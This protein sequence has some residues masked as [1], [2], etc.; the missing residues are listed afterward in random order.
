MDGGGEHGVLR[1]IAGYTANNGG[2]LVTVS[3]AAMEAAICPDLRGRIVSA[4]EKASGKEL[5]AVLGNQTGYIDLFGRVAAQI[6][7]PTSENH[8]VGR[9][10]D[11]DWSRTWSTFA[12]ERGDALQTDVILSPS[13][14]GFYP[15]QWVRRTVTM[16]AKGMQI[17][18]RFIQEKATQ[19][20]L[21]NN[22][23]FNT[24]WLLALPAPRLTKVAVKGGGLEQML[25]LSYAVPGGITGVKAGERLAAGDNM[26]ERF[27]MVIA[28]SDAE[29][30]KLPVA[31]DAAGDLLVRL[32]RGDGTTVILSTPANGWEGIEIKPVI[33]RQYLEITLV[34]KPM[35][36]NKDNKEFDLPDQMLSAHTVPVA[37]SQAAPV[38][39]VSA[40]VAPRLK[41]AADGTA[42]N[43]ADGAKLIWIPAGAFTRGAAAGLGGGDERPQRQI[44]LDGYWIYQHPVTVGQYLKFC[45]ATGKEF[46]PTWGQGMQ[47][48]PHGADD[49]YAV[50]LNWYEADAYAK[51]ASAALPS[52]AQWEKAARATDGRVFPWGNDWDPAKCVSM[53]ATI[54]RFNTGFFPVGGHPDGAS[55][56]GVQDLA[57]NVWE[58]VADWYAYDYYARAPERNPL[59]PETGSHKVLRGGCALFDER[60]S[61]TTA[62]MIMPPH[63][64]DW[65]PTGFRC[66]IIAPGPAGK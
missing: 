45:E 16:T 3:G 28:V 4:V 2:P 37:M 62:R 23:R 63:V 64:R 56:Y 11:D 42:I 19:T 14:Y 5:L 1:S 51:W 27:D 32:D 46:K 44:S 6:W 50:Q 66:V 29:V 49:D 20:T 35:A 52:E 31:A 18:R 12:N 7:L 30:T 41:L 58:W 33:D 8:D 22:F 15:T 59:G 65:T 48:T 55:P 17:S 57:G 10:G 21:P 36:M 47:A 13:F 25:D 53:E 61:R 39:N 60:F 40:P 24:R 26:D 54:Y 9:R 43:E 34:A 38:A